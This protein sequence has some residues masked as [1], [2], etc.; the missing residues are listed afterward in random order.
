MRVF[1]H[2]LRLRSDYTKRT[3]PITSRYSRKSKCDSIYITSSTMKSREFFRIG[4]FLRLT[5][6]RTLHRAD[7]MR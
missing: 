3:A 1:T 7:S 5:I 4:S 2:G 6:L